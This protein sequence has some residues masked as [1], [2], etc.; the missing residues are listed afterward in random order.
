MPTIGGPKNVTHME[1]KAPNY[2]HAEGI[3]TLKDDPVNGHRIS[4][5]ADYRS[6]EVDWHAGSGYPKDGPAGGPYSV[7]V[8]GEKVDL[9]KADSYSHTNAFKEKWVSIPKGSGEAEIEIRKDDEV[10]AKVTVDRQG[11]M[12]RAALGVAEF[13]DQANIFAGM[14]DG[15]LGAMYTED[16]GGLAKRAGVHLVKGLTP[17]MMVGNFLHGLG[18]EKSVPKALG[19]AAVGLV[20]DVVEA[21]FQGIAALTNGVGAVWKAIT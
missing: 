15:F 12:K 8:D 20:G 13:R 10:V 5:R 11:L 16:A 4:F 6:I 2:A 19:G 9:G 7:F 21:S 14:D 18:I 3:D 1:P 17:D